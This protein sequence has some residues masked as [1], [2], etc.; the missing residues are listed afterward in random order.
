M[1]MISLIV[2]IMA[3]SSAE[4]SKNKA[5]KALKSVETLV[6][7]L[8]YE[9]DYY[10][11]REIAQISIK[12]IENAPAKLSSLKPLVYLI[13]KEEEKLNLLMDWL[14]V[15]IEEGKRIVKK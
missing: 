1:A 14:K 7:K 15:E 4:N 5:N 3:F 12:D 9:L 2:S 13:N 6:K 11:N 8:G 10:E